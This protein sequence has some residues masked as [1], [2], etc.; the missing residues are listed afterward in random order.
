MKRLV[1]LI[2]LPLL[3]LSLAGY[4]G[5][6][7]AVLGTGW[8]L[9]NLGALIARPARAHVAVVR[10]WRTSRVSFGQ[11]WFERGPQRG[12]WLVATAPLAVGLLAVALVP[13][14]VGATCSAVEFRWPWVD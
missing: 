9:T 10:R 13:I 1:R 7:F 2:K 5:F 14:V 8:L 11:A 4:V 6:A 12:W 3:A